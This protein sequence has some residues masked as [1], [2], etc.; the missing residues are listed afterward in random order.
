MW[1]CNIQSVWAS[2]T[3]YL[4]D[5]GPYP[6]VEVIGLLGVGGPVGRVEEVGREGLSGE[7]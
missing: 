3:A 1:G 7:R 4:G 6:Y 2:L 5:V